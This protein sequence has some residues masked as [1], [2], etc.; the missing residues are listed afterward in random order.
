MGRSHLHIVIDI[1]R[2]DGAEFPLGMVYTL[3]WQLEYPVTPLCPYISPLLLVPHFILLCHLLST[4]S[5]NVP[6]LNQFLSRLTL[7]IPYDICGLSQDL[8]PCQSP[9]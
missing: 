2:V 6:I 7:L 8:L 4:P 1:L 9:R 5:L 3:L